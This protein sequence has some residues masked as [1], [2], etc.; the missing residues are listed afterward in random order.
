MKKMLFF[1]WDD[2]HKNPNGVNKKIISQI[3]NFICSGISCDYEYISQKKGGFINSI[4]A[5]LPFF[6][7]NPKWKYIEKESECEDYV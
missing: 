7:V 5:R 2:I 4:L 6:N 1:V 3:N